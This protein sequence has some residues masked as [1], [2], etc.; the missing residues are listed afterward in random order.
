MPAPIMC[1]VRSM[2]AASAC[3]GSALSSNT[4]LAFFVFQSTDTD[5]T[6]LTRLSEPC[7][8]LV[9]GGQCR[10]LTRNVAFV[11]SAEYIGRTALSPSATTAVR[12]IIGVRIFILQQKVKG[13]PAPGTLPGAGKDE[14]AAKVRSRRVLSSRH[15][16]SRWSV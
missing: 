1:G 3:A 16:G 2:A 13:K 4:T 9:H 6:P 10:P 8:V 5:L 7:T 12:A 14:S 11:G 15:R